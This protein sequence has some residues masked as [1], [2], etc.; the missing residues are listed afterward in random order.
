MKLFRRFALFIAFAYLPVARANGV[1]PGFD[2]PGLMDRLMNGEI[3]LDETV[4]TGTEF[5][6]FFRAYFDKT[7][8]EAYG[9]IVT[10]Y[11]KYPQLF[12]DMKDAKTTS[13]NADHTVFTY[14]LTMDVTVGPFNETIYPEGK[15]TLNLTPDANGESHITNAITN[16]QDYLN[17]ATETLRLIPYKTGMLVEDDVHVSIKKQSAVSGMVKAQLQKQ[18]QSYLTIFR[19]QLSGN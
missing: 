10:D 8:P 7:T 2:A 9:A 4:N 13:V 17:Y 1:P 15:E 19:T 14:A 6:D 11:E 3:V 16:Y 5:E 18:F 12:D